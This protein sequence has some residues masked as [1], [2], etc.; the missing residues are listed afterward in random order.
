M[1]KIVRDCLTAAV[2]GPFFPD[3]EFHTLIGL[4]RAEVERGLAS[5]PDA[6]NSDDQ[7]LAVSN[8]L[9]NLL[10]YPDREWDAW[11]TY[12]SVQPAEVATVLTRWRGDDEFERD[13]RGYFDR[14]R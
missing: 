13:A 4:E 1:S 12:I 7:D 8:V 2:R 5:W 14:L 6:S 10:G 9:N 11:Q 3:W